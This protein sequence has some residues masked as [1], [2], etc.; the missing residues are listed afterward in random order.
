MKLYYTVKA[1]ED[2][3][4]AQR[5]LKEKLGFSGLL[6]K[7]VRN[8]GLL[9]VNG[10][11]HR[12]KDPVYAGQ[13][14]C[15]DDYGLNPI[16]P[17]PFEAP[18]DIP[19]VYQDDWIL[20]CSK[21]AN[22][23]THPTY[24]HHENNLTARLSSE[25]LHPINRLDRD[26]S[27]LVLIGKNGYAHHRHANIDMLKEYI[28]FVHGTN[29]PDEGCINQ[30][31]ARAPGSIIMREINLKGQEAITYFTCLQRWPQA[32]ISLLKFRLGTGRTH[33]IR[34]HCLYSAM[35]LVGETLYGCNRLFPT[36]PQRNPVKLRLQEGVPTDSE[37]SRDF[38]IKTAEIS[39]PGQTYMGDYLLPR[40]KVGDLNHLCP[41]H[42]NE[43]QCLCWDRFQ[44]RQALHA[45]H[46]SFYQ[47]IIE[48]QLNLYAEPTDDLRALFTEICSCDDSRINE[49]VKRIFKRIFAN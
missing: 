39:L 8:L 13:L 11:R 35:P 5:I 15:A 45:Y 40:E 23:V 17:K 4:T 49:E 41:P 32:N 10:Q 16:Y 37:I 22:L 6:V 33:Q 31:I 2:G 29:I 48:K 27:G 14:L 47:P 42:L 7:Q 1:N 46:L 24:L 30:P 34:V 28:A 25:L 9:T 36:W 18:Q 26:T 20:V 38:N 44:T 12:T 43:E 21:P 3:W 19:I